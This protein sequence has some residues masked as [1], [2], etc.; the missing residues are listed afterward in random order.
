MLFKKAL[1]G[2]ALLGFSLSASANIHYD[3]DSATNHVRVVSYDKTVN[4]FSDTF[5]FSIPDMQVGGTTGVTFDFQNILN[6]SNLSFNPTP[7]FTES[8][9]L[10]FT[11]VH[12]PATNNV[13]GFSSNVLTNG[14]YSF[15]VSGNITGGQGGIYAVNSTSSLI[16]N[17][18]NVSPVPLPASIWILGSTLIGVIGLA[19]RK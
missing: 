10:I 6:I 1:A 4:S 13:T 9:P 8:N 5:T 7:G 2:L 18:G 3:L 19:K 14:Y 16:S 11:A 12:D 17:G 15:D